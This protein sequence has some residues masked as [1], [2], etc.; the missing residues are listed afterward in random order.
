MKMLS[1]IGLECVISPK[2]ISANIIL[3]YLRGLSSTDGSKVQNLYKIVD[4]KAE[5]LEFIAAEGFEYLGVPI[6]DMR[7]KLKKNLIIACII[8]KQRIIYPHGGD[9]IELGDSVIVV[10]SSAETLHG[11]E[12][13]ID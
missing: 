5:A 2:L 6:N 9:T 8:R 11:L 1:S 13:I 7:S 4:G 10:T 3:R 12:D